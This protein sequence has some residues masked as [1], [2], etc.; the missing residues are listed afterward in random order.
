MVSEHIQH[1][2][3]LLPDRP[4]CYLMKNE[5]G[6]VIYVGKATSLKQRVRSYFTGSHDVKTTLLVQDIQDFEVIVTASPMESL[7]LE[8]NLIKKYRPKYNVLLKDDKSYPYI[9]LTKETHP[10]LEVTR[11]VKKGDGVYFGPYPDVAAARE[12]K[13]LFD[14]LYPLRK[15]RTLPKRACLYY[16]LGQC[17]APC[18]HP[19]DP[20]TYEPIIRDIMRFLR[21]SASEVRERVEEEM[22]RAS[23]AWDFERAAELRDLLARLDTVQEKQRVTVTDGADRDVFGYAVEKG[24]I[25]IQILHMRQGRLIERKS[26]LFPYAFS[27]EDAFLSYVTQYYARFDE[28]SMPDEI[29]LP[30]LEDQTAIGEYLGTRLRFPKRGQGKGLID[31]AFENARV[32]L[33][34]HFA[35]AERDERRR[36]EALMGL[37]RSLGL[38]QIERIEAFD[39]AHIQ[40][41]GAVS[42]VVVFDQGEPNKHAY[43]KYRLQKTP[44]GD[45]Y[46]ALRE[47]ARRRFTRLLREKERLP[48]LILVDGGVGQMR[49]LKEVLEDELGL[50]LPVGGMVKDEKHKTAALLFG[51][52]PE[53]VALDRRGAAWMLVQRIQD[54]VHRFAQSYH[55]TVRKQSFFASQLDD[56]PGIGPKRKALLL[57]HFGS[58]KRLQEATIDELKAVG[59]GEKLAQTIQE[60]FQ[61]FH[62]KA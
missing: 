31:M 49:A 34:E 6:D 25:S 39:N 47:V 21:G 33:E 40:G 3:S 26:D 22:H 10:R 12:T 18:I 46:E 32:A 15:C 54:E 58:I 7:I 52:P 29:L 36:E 55:H 2:L 37:M 35:M 11:R 51:E 27:A 38:A 61:L 4:G 19:V 5:D 30:L 14:R 13:R 45:D 28:D 59:M 9:R 1:K 24:W 16:H 43:R 60:Y 44:A 23:E 8:M 62:S 53:E 50:N 57:K 56:I 48:D 42:A 17:L 41:A 20:S